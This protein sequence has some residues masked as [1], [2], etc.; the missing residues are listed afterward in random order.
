MKRTIIIAL[1]FALVMCTGLL[2]GCG[3]PKVASLNPGDYPDPPADERYDVLP[4]YMAWD[5]GSG[6]TWA[7][8]FSV[9]GLLEEGSRPPEPEPAEDE[10]FLVVPEDDPPG[11]RTIWFQGVSPGDVVIT[12]TTKSDKG[13]VVDIQQYAIRVYE[14]RSLALL[15]SEQHDFR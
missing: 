1:I 8:E 11:G 3:S 14:D 10:D 2:A 5:G 9:D 7:Y 6:E 15:Q 13:K 4:V 12:F